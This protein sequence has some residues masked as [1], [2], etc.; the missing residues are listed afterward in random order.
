MGLSKLLKLIELINTE[1]NV[2][3]FVIVVRTN[4]AGF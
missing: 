3:H 4:M 2:I 1:E